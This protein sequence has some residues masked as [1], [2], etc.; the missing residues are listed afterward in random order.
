MERKVV[1][2][3][4]NPVDPQIAQGIFRE[5]DAELVVAD[6]ETE[7]EVIKV[8]HDADAIIRAGGPLTRRVLESLE[9][10]RIIS[11]YAIDIDGIDMDAAT[12]R[13]ICVSY[14]VD[15]TTEE[16]SDHAM[17][18]MLGLARKLFFYDSVVRA[19]QWRNDHKAMVEM[20]RPMFRMS[21]VTVGSIGFGRA[22]QALAR[23]CQGFRMRF[24]A[25]D[26]N[27]PEGFNDELGVELTSLDRVLEESDFL[28]LNVPLTEKTRHMIGAE[29]LKR[30]KP[31]AYLINC[32]ARGAIIDE[33][34]LHTALTKGWI[35]GAAL[36]MLSKMPPHPSPLF[37]LDNAL[38]TPHMCHV[39]DTS[40][41]EMEQRVCREVV[42]FF[43]GEWPPI[44]VNPQVK[45]RVQLQAAR[46]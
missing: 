11:C 3:N 18:M 37:N 26:P 35:A 23:K 30:M 31:T 13:G 44:V 45:E 33:E 16:V 46:L 6:C 42:G 36:D 15:A 4:L 38:I 43:R 40:Y 24:L 32:T 39:S 5:I 8:A 2:L 20:G 34:A 7:D 41:D 27:K 22:A 9:R 25:Y 14:A 28:H 10:C 1:Q 17:A 29:Q 12:E 21:T 19:G